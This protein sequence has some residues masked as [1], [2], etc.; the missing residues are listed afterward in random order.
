MIMQYFFTL[1][2]A[3]ELPGNLTEEDE[4]ELRAA[5]LLSLSNESTAGSQELGPDTGHL[6]TAVSEEHI[7]LSPGSA[8]RPTVLDR[9]YVFAPRD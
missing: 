4:E 9:C 1:L 8:T 6:D 7:G 2:Q 5:L 3:A